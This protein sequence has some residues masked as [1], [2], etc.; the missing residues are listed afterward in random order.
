M[1][2]I[3]DR[4]DMNAIGRSISVLGIISNSILLCI[5]L[6]SKKLKD[7]SY[8]FITNIATSDLITS[9]QVL[10][11]FMS[12]NG[13]V[14]LSE[15]FGNTMCKIA[16]SIFLISYSTSMLSLAIISIYRLNIVSNPF[17]FKQASY[18][19]KHSA[20]LAVFIWIFSILSAIPIFPVLQYTNSTR[21]CDVYYPY[22]SIYT[23]IYFGSSLLVN[24][25]LPG[26][27]VIICYVRIASKLN[28]R[29][30]PPGNHVAF[31]P[32]TLVHS[33]E[34]FKFYGIITAVYM[35]L[36]WPFMMTLLILSITENSQTRVANKNLST[37]VAVTMTFFASNILY[38]LNPVMVM[39]FDKNI[40]SDIRIL[41]SRIKSR[42]I[43]R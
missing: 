31:K 24:F 35:M 17:R 14:L 29:I 12:A 2:T 11:I 1:A 18:I 30:N 41:I 33:K 43:G 42:Y 16:Y 32:R 15:S 23:N 26:V 28:S 37:A 36:S 25:I 34:I 3:D 40:K 4:Y 20:K 22:G 39:A 21:S 5:I 9:I 13:T 38:V 10:V 27:I 7:P 8:V 6:Y 19:Y